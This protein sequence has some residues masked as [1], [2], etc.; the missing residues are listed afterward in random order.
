MKTTGSLNQDNDGASVIMVSRYHKYQCTRHIQNTGSGNLGLRIVKMMTF[1]PLLCYQDITRITQNIQN[2]GSRNLGLRI[3]KMMT[4]HGREE[5][6][7]QNLA[8]SN[9][10]EIL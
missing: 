10:S 3:V 6:Q 9:Q 2:T 1:Q 7:K 8:G 4:V 5:P